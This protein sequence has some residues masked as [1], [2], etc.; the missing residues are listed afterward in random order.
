MRQTD[1]GDGNGLRTFPLGPFTVGGL[2][3]WEN[4][5]PLARTALYAQGENLHV[6]VWPGCRRN[7]IDITRFVAV[8]SRSYVLS[9]SGLLRKSDIPDSF[10][11]RDK[12]LDSFETEVISDGGSCIAAPDGSWLVEPVCNNETLIVQE[13]DFNEVLR[14]RQ[15]FDSCGHYSRPDV[16]QLAVNRERQTVLKE[17][18]HDADRDK[19]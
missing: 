9:V 7:T 15:N 10:P 4:W 11:H 14:E 17:F 19:A 5:M 6:A 18:G 13:I 16:L 2:N 1:G 12:V 8:E 3:C